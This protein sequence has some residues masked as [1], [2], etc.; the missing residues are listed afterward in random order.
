MCWAVG[1]LSLA[2]RATVVSWVPVGADG[3]HD[4]VGNEIILQ[5]GGQ[6]VTLEVRISG[7]DPDA[8]GDPEL[9]T[10]QVTVNAEGYDNGVGA[11]LVPFDDPTA[12]AGAYQVVKM[13]HAF[14]PPYFVPTGGRCD[15]PLT[16]PAGEFCFDNPYFVFKGILNQAAVSTA[17]TNYSWG[18]TTNPGQCKRDEGT[19]TSTNNGTCTVDTD[20]TLY[21]DE[22]CVWSYYAGT[23]ILE[24]PP[25]ASGTYTIEFD[26]NSNNSFLNNCAG[27][28]INGVLFEAGQITVACA[29]DEDCGD[30]NE[31]TDD[32]CEPDNT[33]SNTVNYEVG[34]ECC[35]PGD[36]SVEIIDDGLECTNDDCNEETGEVT[37]TPLPSGTSCGGPPSG[38]CDAQDTCD[39]LGNCQE[40]YQDAGTACDDPTNTECNGADTCDG[41]GNCDDNLAPATTPCG[42]S[43]DSDCDHPDACDGLGECQE[44]LEP[45][46][47]PC[48]QD[49]FC[50]AGKTCTSGA[51]T[52]GEP[53]NVCDDGIPCT[54][55]TCF[56]D[57]DECENTLDGGYCLITDI[58]YAEGEFDPDDDCQECNPTLATDAWSLRPAGSDCNDGDPCTFDD[59]C[60]DFGVCAG[61]YNPE[62]N[63]N[64]VNAIPATEGATTSNNESAGPDDAEASCQPDSNHDVWFVYFASCTGEVFLSTDGTVLHC[65]P[66]E[67]PPEPGNPE[68]C[69]DP[70][71]SVYDECGGNELACDDDSG[72]NWQAA[73][74][75]TVTLGEDYYI[76]VAGY[77]QFTGDIVLNVDTINDCVIDGV[78]YAE[79]ELNPEN[80]CEMCIPDLSTSSWSFALESTPCGDPSENDE[81]D[82]PDACD[83]AGVC[84]PNPKPDGTPC[85][86]DGNECTFDECLAGVCS[87]P[88]RPEGTAC[89]DPS[90]SECDHPDTCDAVGQCQDNFEPFGVSC[91]D[92]SDD[93]CDHP[94]ECDGVGACDANLEP[95]G[96]ECDD[97]DI[98][99]GDDACLDGECVGIPIPEPPL[100]VPEGPRWIGIT[101]LPSGSVAPVALRVTSPTWDC[102]DNYLG[103]VYRCNGVGDRCATPADCNSCSLSGDPCLIDADCPFLGE[104]CIVT[105]DVCIPGM[106]EPVDVNHDG[107][108]DGMEAAVVDDPADKV[109]LT[110]DEWTTGVTRCSRSVTPCTV[111]ADCDWGVCSHF[112]CSDGT[113]DEVLGPCSVAAQ[114]CPSYCII[115]FTGCESEADCP[116][117]G[118]TCI[119]PTCELDEAC[120]EGKVYVD[121]PRIAPDSTYEVVAECGVYETAPG[122]GKTYSWCDVNGDGVANFADIQLQV[123]GFQG[124]LSLVT[125]LSVDTQP[126]APNGIINFADIQWCVIAW[127]AEAPYSSFCDDP[128]P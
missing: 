99:T 117:P 108:D 104:T 34:V 20:C 24:V 111:D 88:P 115:A 123:Q 77:R 26:E 3:A 78:C 100:V 54:T 61:T 69:N 64:C 127:Q 15:V 58:C 68:S 73:L 38:E 60:D 59:V 49:L 92:P 43:S 56:E 36:G 109:V 112:L 113:C 33:C 32:V 28:K 21:P 122:T 37:H 70:V 30:G 9:G 90:D 80:D 118:D 22:V 120:V 128:C 16:C 44:N 71:L 1:T 12:I 98:C 55:D 35:D 27:I 13:C 57:T 66:G 11:P 75:F 116:T 45:N 48:E 89:G 125:Y 39:G 10:Y 103:G 121:G 5:G 126:C 86:E 7:W 95:N 62:C 4:I 2:A 23:L 79:D 65:P 105:G 50:T 85:S 72:I 51:C 67:D 42:D 25:T 8:N 124:M 119:F 94:D 46:G 93:Q 97:G 107:F 53:S 102:V 91:G 81:C 106:V 101:P 74:T 29:T 6:V 18:A 19:C 41:A 84:E 82:S 17:T 110:P 47:T 40:N 76:R 31:C 87:H 63:D 52:G 96:T 14:V 114:G 83:G